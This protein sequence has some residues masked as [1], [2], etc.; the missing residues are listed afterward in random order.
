MFYLHSSIS[1]GHDSANIKRDSV[2]ILFTFVEKFLSFS[3]SIK[4]KYLVAL[5][6]SAVEIIII[7]NFC[8]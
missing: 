5:T 1:S 4:A 2:K 3:D 8:Y 7:S 6:L